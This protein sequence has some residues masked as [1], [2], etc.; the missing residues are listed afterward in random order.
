MN[1]CEHKWK[2][3]HV[4]QGHSM[5]CFASICEICEVDQPCSVVG[6]DGKFGG[7]CWVDGRCTKHI[8]NDLTIPDW[9]LRNRYEYETWTTYKGPHRSE[10]EVFDD[11][12]ICISNSSEKLKAEDVLLILAY[13]FKKKLI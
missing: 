1:K 5:D 7:A 6:C 12:G 3:Q 8:D 4:S 13:H 9:L 2:T 11:G 10:I